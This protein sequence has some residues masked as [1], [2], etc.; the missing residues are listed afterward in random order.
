MKKDKNSGFKDM[1][2]GEHDMAT[3]AKLKVLGHLKDMASGMMQK[4]MSSNWAKRTSDKDPMA[5][6]ADYKKSGFS[7]PMNDGTADSQGLDD[8]DG[9]R[10]ASVAE[11][12]SMANEQTAQDANQEHTPESLDAEIARLTEMKRRVAAKNY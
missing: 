11:H 7:K 12:N 1:G 5:D 8:H 10:E 4:D 6:K 3:H 2:P 9:D